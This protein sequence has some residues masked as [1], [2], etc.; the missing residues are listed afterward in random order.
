MGD[1]AQNR[2]RICSR[3]AYL[4][5]WL[6]LNLPAT[7]KSE[8]FISSEPIDRA[9]WL[10]LLA[11][12]AFDENAGRI[13]NCAE[14]G[15]RK[16]QQLVQVTLSEVKRKC[17]LWEWRDGDIFVWGYPIEAQ[18]NCDR[19]RRLSKNAAAKRWEKKINGQPANKKGNPYVNGTNG[20]APLIHK[21]SP[22][23][24]PKRAAPDEVPD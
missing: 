1:G 5:I 22:R 18:E 12:C 19:L 17:L 10:C 24:D 7:I 15:D 4:V 14:W 23:L 20:R 13:E 3:L 6:N 2:R 9:T 16:W 21:N 11:H 8:R